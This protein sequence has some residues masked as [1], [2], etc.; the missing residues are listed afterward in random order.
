MVSYRKSPKIIRSNRWDGSLVTDIERTDIK[1]SATMKA[2]TLF[3]IAIALLIGLGVAAG[4]KYFGLFKGK[5]DVPVAKEESIL[6][7]VANKDLYKGIAITSA[8]VRVREVTTAAERQTYEQIRGKLMPPMV[9]AAQ[10]K[11][12]T[13]KILADQML[14]RDDF[15]EEQPEPV[16]LRINEGMRSVNVSVPKDRCAG[17]VIQMG[18]YVDVLLTSRINNDPRNPA[19]ETKTAVL[20]RDCRVIMKRNR[21][22][23]VLATDPD[24]PISFTLEVNPYRASLIDYAQHKGLITLLPVRHDDFTPL[25][26]TSSRN[27]PKAFSDMN[28]KEYRDEDTRVS[29]ILKGDYVVSDIDLKRVLDIKDP[30]PPEPGIR[31]PIIIGITP[32]RESYFPP[33]GSTA[34]RYQGP[35]GSSGQQSINA[36]IE[37]KDCPDCPKK[38]TPSGFSAPP[39]TIKK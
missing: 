12:P 34:P 19:G 13:K 28:S 2:S 7:L 22:V 11:V 24:A 3:V 25:Q 1:G 39:T 27:L 32:T 10:L 5:E 20:A 26:P 35:T 37:P 36:P 21:L 14:R 18:E 31:V 38:E 16:S 17:G 33:P 29:N 9:S 23:N 4:A 6:V 15:Q 30:R 8:D